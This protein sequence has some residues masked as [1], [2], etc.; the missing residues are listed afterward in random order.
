MSMPS[1]GC[2]L[3]LTCWR[4]KDMLFASGDSYCSALM[5]LRGG[6]HLGKPSKGSLMLPG[7]PSELFPTSTKLACPSQLLA[8]S[9][10]LI[11]YKT[12]LSSFWN[13][14]GCGASGGTGTQSILMDHIEPDIWEE[15]AKMEKE[16][17][18]QLV[19]GSQNNRTYW[20]SSSGFQIVLWALDV[21]LKPIQVSV[22]ICFRKCV[23]V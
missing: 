16:V 12:I 13:Q 20:S 10:L 11:S 5:P 4:A 18:W 1:M 21:L 15:K 6:C 19:K 8:Q 23:H 9:G 2:F 3:L 7:L 17:K 22:N 14:A